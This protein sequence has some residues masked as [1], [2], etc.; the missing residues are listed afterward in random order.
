MTCLQLVK[1]QYV[2]YVGTVDVTTG[3]ERIISKAHSSCHST[4][5]VDAWIWFLQTALVC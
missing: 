3:R 4:L 5:Q 2:C 1:V